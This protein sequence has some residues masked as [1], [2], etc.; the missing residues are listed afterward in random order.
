MKALWTVAALLLA[1]YL[2]VAVACW[3]PFWMSWDGIKC[4]VRIFAGCAAAVLILFMPAI[5]WSNT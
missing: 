1:I 4:G 3:E 2:L 5:L